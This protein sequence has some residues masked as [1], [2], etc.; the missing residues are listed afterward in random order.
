[1]GVSDRRLHVQLT[2]Q[3]KIPSNSFLFEG[4]FAFA[5]FVNGL[6]NGFFP[7]PFLLNL[8]IKFRIC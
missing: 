4:I 8:L 3:A 6:R 7:F 2:Q 1:M 5:G